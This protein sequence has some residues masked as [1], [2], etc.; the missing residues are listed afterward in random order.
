MKSPVCKC[1]GS[2]DLVGSLSKL[3]SLC[4]VGLKLKKT[5]VVWCTEHDRAIQVRYN[6]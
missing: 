2:K 5:N 4:F 1:C 3:C 6:G